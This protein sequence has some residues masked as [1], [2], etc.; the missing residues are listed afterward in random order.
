MSTL[1][2]LVG[3]PASGKST[4]SKELE[5]NGVPAISTDKIRE[6]IFGDENLQY[7]PEWLKEHG[8]TGS[9]DHEERSAFAHIII[10]DLF[11]DKINELLKSGSDVTADATNYTKKI[12]K[13]LLD[14]C[15]KNADRVI[16]LVLATPVEVCIERNAKRERTVRQDS[17]MKMINN[18]EEPILEEGFTDI[19]YIYSDENVA[20]T[21]R[22]LLNK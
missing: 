17:F 4:V 12:R 6:E 16:A 1:Y 13:L 8:Y 19:K 3:I 22:Q 18:Y 21:V 2:V 9:D 20:E 10:F 15:K 14:S 5:K 7:T 11:Y